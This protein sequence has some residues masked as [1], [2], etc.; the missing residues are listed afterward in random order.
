MK[1]RL[2]SVLFTV[3]LISLHSYSISSPKPE[4]GSTGHRTIGLIAE[5]HLTKKASKKITSLLNGQ[6]LAF[7]STYGDEIKSDDRYD[8]Y[9]SWHYVNFPIEGR[10]EDSAKNEKGDIIMGIDFCVKVLEDEN[11][12][13]S[14]KVF[15]LK[16]LVHLIGD[17]HQPLHVGVAE[18]RGGNDIK[19]KWHYK[20]SNLHRVWDSELIESWNMS[21]TELEKNSKHLSKEQ[22][23]SIQSGTVNDWMY[24]SRELVKKVYKSTKNDDKLGYK[25]SYENFDIVMNQLQK[26]GIRLAKLL[27]DIYD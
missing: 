11:S 7:V 21:Y 24:D 2:F 6:S 1:I 22:L 5:N 26:G 20:K 27:N 12:S 19:V 15:F 14:D 10:Y 23:N 4:W 18:D 3:I 25:Y 8:K 17:L 9:Y 16:F 13:Q